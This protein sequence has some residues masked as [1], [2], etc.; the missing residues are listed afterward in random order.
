MAISKPDEKVTVSWDELRYGITSGKYPDILKALS[1]Y[2]DMVLSGDQVMVV[3]LEVVNEFKTNQVVWKFEFYGEEFRLKCTALATGMR[4]YKIHDTL[5]AHWTDGTV[6][7]YTVDQRAPEFAVNASNKIRTITRP[8]L[9]PK[10]GDLVYPRVAPAPRRNKPFVTFDQKNN[11][12]KC[13][14]WLRD[15]TCCEHVIESIR[16][17]DDWSLIQ[18]K[19]NRAPGPEQKAG[20]ILRYPILG[21]GMEID[22]MLIVRSAEDMGFEGEKGTIGEFKYGEAV[23][24]L[25][26]EYTGGQQVIDQV[27][28]I[29]H[30]D[31]R[32]GIW[33]NAMNEVRQL[34]YRVNLPCAWRLHDSTNTTDFHNQCKSGRSADMVAGVNTF[35]QIMFDRCFSCYEVSNSHDKNIPVL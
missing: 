5:A 32:Y 27:E 18:L 4:I 21:G 34:N 9:N 16:N 29:I 20:Y 7:K 23:Q 35:C 22:V 14:C 19:V 11:R 10:L 25:V 17:G 26:D 28:S 1:R 33:K 2:A 31:P 15:E 8:Q 6:K 13:A 3:S 30:A 24:M 12:W